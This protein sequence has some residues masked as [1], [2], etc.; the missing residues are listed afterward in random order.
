[1]E[2]NVKT[3]TYIYL[4]LLLFLVP[5]PWLLAWLVAVA[6]HEVCHWVA[7]NLCGGEIYRL[8]VGIG[9]ANMEGCMLQGWK[10]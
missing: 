10:S 3:N 9:G 4:V 1:M 6:F 8:T 2:I 5:L 7:V